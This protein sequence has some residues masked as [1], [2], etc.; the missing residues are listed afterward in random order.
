MKKNDKLIVA[1]GVIILIVAGSLVYSWAP[2]LEDEYEH[3][4]IEQLLELESVMT[5]NTPEALSISDECVF[6]PLIVTP[7]ACNYDSMGN[8]HVAPLYVKNFD[9]L[10]RSVE[11]VESQIGY[12]VTELKLGNKDVKNASID[13]A[14]QYWESSDAALIIKYDEEGYNLGVAATPMASYLSIPVIV[15][16]EMDNHVMDLLDM[17]DV[18]YTIICGDLK[19]YGE[20][21]QYENIDAILDDSIELVQEKFGDVEYITVTNPRDAFPPEVLDSEVVVYEKEMLTASSNVFPAQVLNSFTSQSNPARH[22]IEI[23]EDYEYA[24]VKLDIRNLQDPEHVELFGDNIILGGSLTNYLR[25]VA[26][27]AERDDQGNIV[28][29]RLHF[30][31]VFYDK[32][33]EKFSVTLTSSYHVL[34]Q[35]EYEIEVT[36]EEL[37]HPYYPMMPKFSSMAPYLTAYHKGIIFANPNFAF[38]PTDEIKYN[39]HT[40]P[41]NTQVLFNPDLIPVIN[42]HVYENIHQPMNNLL[43]KIRDIDIS[44]TVEYLTRDYQ[45]NPVYVA[46]L[47]DTIML[48]HYYYR[49][50]HSDPF[51]NAQKGAY[52]TNVPSDFIY[53]NTDPETYSLLQ[54][55]TD[56]LERDIYGQGE[57]RFPVAENIVGRLTGYDVQDISALIARNFFYEEVIN[58]LEEWKDNAAVL[59]GAG[60]EMQKLPF[61]TWLN[62]AIFSDTEPQKFPSGEKYFLLKRILE[63]FEEGGFNARGAERGAAQMEGYSQEALT[64][65]KRAS[66]GNFIWF[67][68]LNIKIRQGF[69]NIESLKPKNLMNIIFGGEDDVVVGGELEKT[70]NFI[71]TDSHAI[72]FEKEFGDVLMNS[73]G[74]PVPAITGPVT[75]F[76]SKLG[77]RSQLDQKGAF[78]VREVSNVDMGPSVMMIEGCGSGKI[79]GMIPMN[80]LANTYM[81]AGVNAYISPTTMSAFYGALEPRPKWPLLG[82]GVGFGIVG[83]LQTL[84]NYKLNGEYP[85]IHF[86]QWIFE[87]ALYDMY[88]NDISIGEA[89]RN[90]KNAFLPDQFDVTYRW[91]PPLA[92]PDSIPQDIQDD[93]MSTYNS[94]SAGNDARFPVEKFAT[95][96]QI[97]LLGDPAFNPYEPC[98]EGS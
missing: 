31:T 28:E 6:Y 39:G 57:E 24:L 37:S 60:C 13:I 90:A 5:K 77:I 76:F 9:D 98:N 70:S 75:R 7:L 97:N 15:T 25:T 18:K 93:I 79:D 16:D 68:K 64:M 61:I 33:G 59:I 41:G 83:Y 34:K 92:I 45:E 26:Y 56:H 94:M 73:Q 51:E 65:I 88:D 40:L 81:H 82:N 22:I 23:P 21:L 86:N 44:D 19:P 69:Q 53:G 1:L 63:N 14:E 35:A 96:F 84:I 27:P 12:T 52:G 89:L 71:I 95:I 50:P 42:K 30:E 74:M 91:T 3:I 46:L 55:D 48:P 87:N 38:S 47:G 54:Y 4:E 32:G 49:S 85:P 78:G 43:A 10:S 11:R 66:L 20:T 62:S 8:Q 72:W 29:D 2:V 80:S 17:L 36:V 67:N 58:D